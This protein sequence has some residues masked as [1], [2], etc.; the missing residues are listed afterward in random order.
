MSWLMVA[1]GMPM[2]VILIFGLW[3]LL[4]AGSFALRPA[5]GRLGPIAAQAL[6]VL[7]ASATGVAANLI[8]VSIKVP[9]NP[10]WAQSPELPLILLQGFG[11]ALSPLVLGG[12][13]VTVVALITSVGLRRM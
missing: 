8:A 1:G 4:S 11:E 12:S 10:E 5:A 2:V 7:C 3:A 6:A 9:G 13:V